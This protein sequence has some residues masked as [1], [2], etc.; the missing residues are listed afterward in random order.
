[1]SFLRLIGYVIIV[2]VF[3]LAGLVFVCFLESR[4]VQREGG[5]SFLAS[6][7]HALVGLL[8]FIIAIALIVIAIYSFKYWNSTE[9]A[10]K[11]NAAHPLD[12]KIASVEAMIRGGML[13][14]EGMDKAT[15][16]LQQLKSQRDGGTLPNNPP[17]PQMP[18]TN[19]NATP[20]NS[21]ISPQAMQDA[22][23]IQSNPTP[24][25]G[26]QPYQATQ[27]QFS[28]LKQAQATEQAELAGIEE[29]EKTL[30]KDLQ[31]ENKTPLDPLERLSSSE[32]RAMWEINAHDLELRQKID[33]I[34]NNRARK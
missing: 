15:Q 32:L 25:V 29:A 3:N 6:L 2:I 10:Q 18:T 4:R 7:W 28:A 34:L 31:E 30:N 19:M 12:S 13:S 16:F 33:N 11:S 9:P 21:G 1:M 22:S 23:A 14:P 24:R 8:K 20:N 17:T 5:S 27:E 26:P